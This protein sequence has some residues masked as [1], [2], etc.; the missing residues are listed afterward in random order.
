MTTHLQPGEFSLLTQCGTA[1]AGLLGTA[2]GTLETPVFMPVGTQGTV[3]ALGP[4]DLAALGPRIILGNTY[5][6]YLRPGDERVARLGGLHQ[7][8]GWNGAI[9]TDSGGFQV[10][11]LQGLRRIEEEGVT[12]QSHIDGSRHLFSPEKVVSIQRNLGSDI[13]MVLDECVPYGADREYTAKSLQLTTRWARR[14]REA[15]PALDR[16]QLL[17]GIVQGGF[18]PDLRAESA[19]QLMEIP[20]DGFAIGGLSVGESRAEMLDILAHTAPLLPQDKPRYLMGVGTPRDLLDGIALGVDMF[21]CVLPTRNARNG[22][23]FTSFGKT[24]IKLAKYAEDPAPLDPACTC[25]TCRTFSRAYLRHLYMARELLAYRLNT[26]HNI[27]YYLDLMRQARAAILEHRFEAFR[28][29]ILAHY[30]DEATPSGDAACPSS[31]T[32]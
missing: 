23:L 27:H 32:P 11:S 4:D 20:F 25:Y 15:H 16:G 9:L 17:F 2:H 26:I 10:F 18:F 31:P 12:F 13:M 6:L 24:N 8:M 22:T 7:F 21:D 5:H 29:D 1:R 30:E 28:R 3:K 19:R 14:C